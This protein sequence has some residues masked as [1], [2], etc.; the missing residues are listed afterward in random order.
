M[1][2]PI[3]NYIQSFSISGK[4]ESVE[5]G[6]GRH[7]DPG[8]VSA[9]GGTDYDKHPNHSRQSVEQAGKNPSCGATMRTNYQS[10]SYIR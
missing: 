3:I 9:F 4:Q 2:N 8:L 1:V 7:V 6:G 10:E 5:E